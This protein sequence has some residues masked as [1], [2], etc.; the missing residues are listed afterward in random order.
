MTFLRD[1][2]FIIKSQTERMVLIMRIL[3]I[4]DVKKYDSK[5]NRFIL[6]VSIAH[7]IEK[8]VNK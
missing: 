6:Y 4:Y 8:E 5:Q 1:F 3:Q 7:S 2:S